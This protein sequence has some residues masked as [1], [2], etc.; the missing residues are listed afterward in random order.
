MNYVVL[1]LLK[2][3][4]KTIEQFKKE[5]DNSFNFR[6]CDFVNSL[7]SAE[8]KTVHLLFF[9]IVF[10]NSSLEITWDLNRD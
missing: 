2:K 8:L 4:L 3:E 5:C 6:I 1:D 7:G 9:P 10:F